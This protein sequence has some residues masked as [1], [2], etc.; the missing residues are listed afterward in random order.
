MEDVFTI[1]VPYKGEEREFEAQLQ[2]T[3]YTHRFKVM[4]EGMEVHFEPDEERQYR[5]IIPP[6][7]A[8]QSHKVDSALFQAV[9]AT[10]HE[11]LS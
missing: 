2:M 3:G 8:H 4:I 11:I 5:A 10:L 6:E 7:Q 9:A 1:T